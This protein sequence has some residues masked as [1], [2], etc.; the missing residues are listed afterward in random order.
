MSLRRLY[1]ELKKIRDSPPEIYNV[2]PVYEDDLTL[3]QAVILGS[4]DTEYENG[5]FY[6]RVKFPP[7]YPFKP[8]EIRFVTPIMHPNI[9]KN[10]KICLYILSTNWHPSLTISK[11]LPC[12]DSLMRDPNPSDALV[13]ELGCL[14][15]N[16]RLEYM[17]NV[18]KHT[19]NHAVTD[20]KRY[21]MRSRYCG[22]AKV[23]SP[24][25]ICRRE[26]RNI[27]WLTFDDPT[28]LSLPT[29][30]TCDN[31]D[32]LPLPAR[33]KHYLKVPDYKQTENPLY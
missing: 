33:M 31:V 23:Y 32:K 11:V 15:S 17:S 16:D 9:D 8:P 20:Y 4:S 18:K 6:L 29:Q 2:S 1:K 3:W 19:Q 7:E 12:V 10:G 14:Y 22:P 27:L 21:A 5:L 28:K 25:N 26:I 24:L 30:F 13:P